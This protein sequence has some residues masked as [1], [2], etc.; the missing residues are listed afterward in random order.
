MENKNLNI[1]TLLYS[2]PTYRLFY[3]F[4]AT[5]IIAISLL[6]IVITFTNNYT[7]LIPAS[8]GIY[9]VA[10]INNVR[11]MDP[12]FANNDTEIAISKLV[13]SGL[14]KKSGKE[15]T[16]DIAD[17]ITRSADGLGI[18]IK[19]KNAKF[20]DASNITS[21]DVA[22]TIELIQDS[23]INSPRHKDWKNI[24][25]IIID[26]GNLTLKLKSSV[27]NIE[28]VLTQGI[29][30][31]SEW[32][33]LPRGSLSL[34]NLNINAIGSGPYKLRNTIEQN[35]IL[36]EIDLAINNNYKTINTLPYIQN[37]IFKIFSDKSNIYNEI[38][39]G[40]LY[41]T[42]G[43]DP[44]E[45][46]PILKSNGNIKI[47]SAKM[48]R[49]FGLFFNPNNDKNLA[50]ISYRSDL[51]NS[52]KIDKIIKDVLNNYGNK[53]SYIYNKNYDNPIANT[54]IMSKS[55]Y[56]NRKI[57]IYTVNNP[58]LIKVA[59]MIKE[60]WA[61]IGIDAQIKTSELGEFHQDVVKNRNFSVLLFAVDTY[62]NNDIYNLWHSS[63]RAYPGS[64]ITNY[65]SLTLDNN[66]E[67]LMA[68]SNTEQISDKEDSQNL[69]KQN[70]QTL[71]ESI[72]DEL[73]RNVAWVPLYNPYMIFTSDKNLKINNITHIYNTYEFLEGLNDAYINT[74]KV[75]T[76]FSKDKIYKKIS[77]FVH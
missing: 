18:N 50:D 22:Y 5:I 59:N 49:S 16:Y 13:Y 47:I 74:E 69:T 44:S 41:T 70:E 66:L 48:H 11:Y 31:K 7:T 28:E 12:I 51:R 55:N 26:G 43:I 29:I 72:N 33:T 42:L 2:M 56:E 62:D 63:G 54:Y 35:K 20:S 21:S 76:I 1:R 27:N 34:S 9:K 24:E 10:S 38:K 15:Y 8:G 58:D 73:Y 23:L 6:G 4:L 65:Y 14:L 46:A 36:N 17:T 60:D 64:N 57:D 40:E 67:N 32:V 30:K 77:D 53:A 25:V 61:K 3:I 45:L 68:I 37:I 52:I 39:R 75:Y 71:Y 19:L